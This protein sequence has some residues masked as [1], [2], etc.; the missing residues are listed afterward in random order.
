MKYKFIHLIELCFYVLGLYL[1]LIWAKWLP[2]PSWIQEDIEPV[3]GILGVLSM[4][5][6]FIWRPKNSDNNIITKRMKNIVKGNW[7]NVKGDF[8]VGDIGG[9]GNEPVDKKNAVE[10]NIVKSNKFRVGDRK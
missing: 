9:K 6:A 10:N 7:I 1:C 5:G 4:I 8:Y 2:R 3:Y